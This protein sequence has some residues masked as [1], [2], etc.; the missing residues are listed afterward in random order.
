MKKIQGLQAPHGATSLSIG[1][2]W[3]AELRRVKQ[4]IQNF[5]ENRFHETEFG[6]PKLDGVQFKQLSLL[7][8]SRLLAQFLEEEVKEAI[9]DCGDLKSPGP[10]G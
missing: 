3:A 4:E 10:D 1:G 9:W 6:R 8:N 7:E 2:I 5:F